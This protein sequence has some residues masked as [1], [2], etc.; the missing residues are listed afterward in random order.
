[1][2]APLDFPL[3]QQIPDTA[4][5][6][7]DPVRLLE[8]LVS[9]PSVNPMGSDVDGGI[10]HEH[11]LTDWLLDFFQQLDVPCEVQEVLPGRCNVLARLDIPGATRTVVLDAHQDTV[12]VEGM[13]IDPFDPV[14]RN[15]R[16]YGR[17]ACDVKGGMAAM[18]AA[19]AQLAMDRPAGA[20]NVVM[21]CTCDEEY[22]AKGAIAL[23]D[24][25]KQLDTSDP[26][27]PTLPDVC[28]VA[29]PTDLHVVPAHLGV[30]RWKLQTLGR[31]CHS[32]RPHEGLNAIYLMAELI[33]WIQ[34]YADE[35]PELV[36][37]HPLCGKPTL[38]V[39]RINGGVSVNIVPAECEVEIDRRL[40]P[41]EDPHQ[42]MEHLSSYLQARSSVPF[43]MLTP[44]V[45]A[46]ALSDEESVAWSDR[47]LFEIEQTGESREKQG[48]WYCTNAA[49]FATAGVPSLVFGPG[50]IAQAHTADEW[51]DLEQLQRAKEIYARFCM[52][53]PV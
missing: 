11:R 22:T 1:M 35:L 28:V 34:Q 10:Y 16:L 7:T 48:A 20:S 32:S 18:L 38:S 43:R 17:G 19:F 44:W 42:A 37:E 21:S 39:G 36:G 8:Q 41:G 26:I 49:S 23:S 25:W 6:L 51:I 27:F 50:S 31:A 52:E 14:I 24:R 30:V 5:L 46:P 4:S 15:G 29:E 12:P 33:R 47:L 13:T 3:T 40:I 9:I 45:I 2:S 53:S